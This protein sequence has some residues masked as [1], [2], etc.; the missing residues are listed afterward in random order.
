MKTDRGMKRSALRATLWSGG[1]ALSRQGVQFVATLIL[2]RLLTP[3]DFGLLAML[4][5]FVSVAAA[6]A[7]G[8]LTV[9]LIQRT[10]IDPLD[11]STVFWCNLSLGCLL[12]VGLSAAAPL[13]AL[14]FGEPR[15]RDIVSVMSTV[16]IA[17]SLFAVHAARLSKRLNFKVQAISGGT[18]ATV[19]GTAAIIMAV[20]GMGVWA[21]VVQS[22]AMAVLNCLMLWWLSRWRPAL[23]FSIES[24]KKLSGFSGYHLASTLMETAYAPICGVVVGKKFGA[25]ALGYYVTA[26]NTRQ[27]PAS[28]VAMLVS[29][30]A[31]PMFSKAQNEQETMRR[32]LQLSNRVIMLCYAPIMVALIVL[33]DPIV[34]LLYGDQ[35]L[36]AVA[37][38]QVLALAG[39]LYPL[40]MINVHALI[41]CGQAQLMFKLELTKK[42][43]GIAVLVVGSSFGLM[44]LAWSQV[45][46]SLIALL[47]NTYYVGKRFDYGVSSQLRDIVPSVIAASFVF[48]I[49]GGVAALCLESNWLKIVAVVSSGILVYAGIVFFGKLEAGKEA[50]GLLATM[51]ADRS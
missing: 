40:H 24:L 31:L 3:A 38:L 44:G 46:N 39:L 21:L 15:L 16:I 12:A 26:E 41:G 8:G 1:D 10:D 47:I 18:A 19:A 14:Y 37:P 50:I 27:L 4:A 36:L 20:N 11:E 23:K 25:S 5:V 2:A 33:A 30:V 48:P 9:A 22:V 28:F 35:W 29:R 13:L 42:A 49:A 17:R 45:V 43:T 6:L 7:D 32:G 34:R 51:K